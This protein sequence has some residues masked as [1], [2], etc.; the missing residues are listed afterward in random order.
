[1]LLEHHARVIANHRAPAPELVALQDTYGD[2]LRLVAEDVGEEPTAVAIAEAAAEVGGLDVVVH[3][4]PSP[5]TSRWF[6]C[7]CRLGMR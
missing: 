5:A 3:N 2:R 6:G 7:R 4:G 1:V